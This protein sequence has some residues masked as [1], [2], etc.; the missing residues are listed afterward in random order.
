MNTGY[1]NSSLIHDCISVTVR[2]PAGKYCY[3]LL[4]TALILPLATAPSCICHSGACCFALTVVSLWTLTL[5]N[6]HP[7]QKKLAKKRAHNE[8]VQLHLRIFQS[9]SDHA[10][11]LKLKLYIHWSTQ[12]ARMAKAV[13]QALA[14]FKPNFNRLVQPVLLIIKI[15]YTFY[16]VLSKVKENFFE[17]TFYDENVDV[18]TEIWIRVNAKS[19]DEQD[20]PESSWGYEVIRSL[21]KHALIYTP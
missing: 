16:V 6:M 8:N 3:S 21:I 7:R 2:Q 17:D 15:L 4:A 20:K 18:F 5:H 13:L 10:L 19:C 12:A 14:A 9:S 11:L 1:T